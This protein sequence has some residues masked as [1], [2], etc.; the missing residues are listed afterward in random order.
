MP[1]EFTSVQHILLD[2]GYEGGILDGHFVVVKQGDFGLGLPAILDQ[3]YKGEALVFGEPGTSWKGYVYA[4]EQFLSTKMKRRILLIKPEEDDVH[5]AGPENGW[6]DYEDWLD[7]D[8]T[9]GPS[10][11]Q[12]PANFA[13]NLDDISSLVEAGGWPKTIVDGNVI[14][15]QYALL[16]MQPLR[17]QKHLIPLYNKAKEQLKA[18]NP[19]T[20]REG[21]DCVWSSLYRAGPSGYCPPIALAYKGF[22]YRLTRGISKPKT[23][24]KSAGKPPTSSDLVP[25]PPDDEDPA[26]DCVS[27]DDFEDAA[28]DAGQGDGGSLYASDDEWG[29]PEETPKAKTDAPSSDPLP[30]R[31]PGPSTGVRANLPDVPSRSFESQ[32]QRP[33]VA[34]P[35]L[36]IIPPIK[37]GSKYPPGKDPR[38]ERLRLLG[39]HGT[40]KQNLFKLVDSGALDINSVGYAPSKPAKPTRVSAQVGR[41]DIPPLMADQRPTNYS[42]ASRYASQ[43][44]PNH[45]GASRY[46][47]HEPRDRWSGRN[48]QPSHRP[49]PRPAEVLSLPGYFQVG[50]LA[51]VIRI[52]DY[53]RLSECLRSPPESW[54]SIR[55][56]AT[57]EINRLKAFLKRNPTGR[58]QEFFDKVYSLVHRNN[59]LLLK[60]L[61]VVG[62][63]ADF[64]FDLDCYQ[65]RK[66]R[67]PLDFSDDEY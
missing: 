60:V 32:P 39:F 53:D 51:D 18:Y 13:V 58:I 22:F 30:A 20:Y 66:E 34:V 52:R 11:D 23:L 21:Y 40:D 57:P 55:M 63:M 44:P 31:E 16:L 9:V 12:L 64:D 26:H 36:P 19:E 61:S 7:R 25:I 24:P 1:T 14:K 17:S 35:H 10:E 46:A 59:N 3:A 27:D 54:T 15:G 62:T 49:G 29:I 47:S 37:P 4:I 38:G 28:S 8:H 42:G 45:G 33:A 56:K 48:N 67:D 5:G 43:G 6:A 2:C 50:K 65:A 41:A